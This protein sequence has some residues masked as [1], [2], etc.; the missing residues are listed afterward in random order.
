[1]TAANGETPM[2][3]ETQIIQPSL[4]GKKK[5]IRHGRIKDRQEGK[6]DGGDDVEDDEIEAAIS[7]GGNNNPE[8]QQAVSGTGPWAQKG[9]VKST[10]ARDEDAPHAP[11]RSTLLGCVPI[12]LPS[13]PGFPYR[14]VV[15]TLL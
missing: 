9:P 12:L 8:I 10:V 5:D 3:V 13:N 4:S 7:Q 1:L 15:G 2:L 14:R 11:L 6:Y